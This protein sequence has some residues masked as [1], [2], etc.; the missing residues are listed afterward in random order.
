MMLT[1]DP[2]VPTPDSS[3]YNDES[4][5]RNGRDVKYFGGMVNYADKLVGKLIS[6]LEELKLRENT[7]VIFLGDNGTHPVVTSQWRGKPYA[8]GKG[9][10]TGN[11]SHVPLIVNWPKK[12]L[13]PGS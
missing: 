3:N 10:Q 8:G 5:K 4:V 6:K 1:H 11:G 13:E 7:L 12:T 9:K 2:F